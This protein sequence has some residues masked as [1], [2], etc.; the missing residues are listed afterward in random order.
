MGAVGRVRSRANVSWA[1]FRNI[2]YAWAITVPLSLVVSALCMGLLLLLL[3]V[4]PLYVPHV[5]E[6]ANSTTTAAGGT[7]FY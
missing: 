7:V 6:V 1:T 2:V 5:D 3:K 4:F